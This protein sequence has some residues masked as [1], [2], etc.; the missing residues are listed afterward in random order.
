MSTPEVT[1]VHPLQNQWSIYEQI[2]FYD[3]KDKKKGY[4]DSYDNICQFK[5]VEGFW[6]NW[7]RIPTVTWVFLVVPKEQPTLL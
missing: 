6:M 3:D 5:T 4:L 2:Q 1:K 7:N